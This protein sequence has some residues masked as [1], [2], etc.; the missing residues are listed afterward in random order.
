MAL[1]TAQAA[2]GS[3]AN[4][5]HPEMRD[6]RARLLA[7]ESDLRRALARNEIAVFYQPIV[8]L[9]T[10]ELVGFEALARWRHPER[11][12]LSPAE[13]IDIAET[14]GLM[15]DIGEFIL[16]QAA[17]QLGIWQRVHR[18][19]QPFFVSVN[20]SPKQ[21]E[22]P[23]F[24]M[25]L[26]QVINRETLV[27]GSLKLEITEDVIVPDAGRM[28][29]LLREFQ[30]LG[31]GLACD[32]FGTGFSSLASLRDFP[33][34]TLK[35]DKS[36][37]P[38]NGEIDERNAKVITTITAL[39]NSLDM[40]VVAEGIETQ[41]QIDKLAMLGVGFGQG[42]FIAEPETAAQAGMRLSALRQVDPDQ[43]TPQA[44][45]IAAASGAEPMAPPSLFLPVMQPTA[46]LTDED[47]LEAGF[48]LPSIFSIP[49]PSAPRAKA[50]R[51]KPAKKK[52]G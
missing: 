24:R 9:N 12:L 17:R 22:R 35:M 21:L 13:F 52:R 50:K 41:A 42:Y 10:L 20:V 1:G 32:D 23:E 3:R 44:G 39:A 8:Y 11:G 34:D 7:L 5:H 2:G 36:F 38:A 26:Q 18:Q 47:D 25:Q 16:G 43:F 33:F 51:R 30:A 15:Q 14:A 31:V 48:E 37:M 40:V 45:K 46:K 4:I 28:S 27:P 49:D 29:D 19:G 6:E